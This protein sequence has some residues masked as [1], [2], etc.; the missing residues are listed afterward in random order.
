[1]EAIL[2]GWEE[3]ALKIWPGVQPTDR[4]LRDHAEEM[5]RAVVED[6]K[7]PQSDPEKIDK[8]MGE[9]GNSQESALV[10]LSL[11][12]HAV[13]RVE[14]GFDLRSLVAEYRA[15]RA[16]VLHL[17]SLNPGNDPASQM[18]DIMRFN[19][20]VDQLLA[21][22]ISSYSE[23]VEHSREIFLGILGHDLRTPLHVVSMGAAIMESHCELSG[24]GLKMTSQIA[25]SVREMER[26]IRD[27]LDFTCARLGAK[28]TVS[29]V[30]INMEQLCGEVLE[31]L[32]AAHPS[33]DFRFESSGEIVGQLDRSRVRQLISNLLGNAVQHGSATTPI[34]LII[35]E[36][37][38]KVLI[39]VRNEG[40]AIQQDAIT[41]IFDPLRRDANNELTRPAGSIGLGLYIARE[42]ASAHG[43]T[44]EV[45]SDDKET[46]FLARLPGQN[47]V[48]S[49]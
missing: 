6:M 2:A 32:Q 17:W 49:C 29:R 34:H 43:G 46:V 23:C 18:E 47:T 4:L 10:D 24:L 35:K 15:L 13:A 40:K 33:R 41:R 37:D 45:T 26:M 20:A 1:M 36:E 5:L 7:T 31:E 42:V 11:T 27:L 22:S 28:M 38:D 3:F 39:G 8:S 44:I 21:E 30:P 25:T 14:S 9:S 19:E 16:N 48:A 12:R